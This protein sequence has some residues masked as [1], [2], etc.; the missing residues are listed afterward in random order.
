MTGRGAGSIQHEIT[1]G[2]LTLVAI[3]DGEFTMPPGFLGSAEVHAALAGPD[4]QVRLPI[5][6]FLLPGA[7]PLLIDL[8][9]GPGPGTDLLSGGWLLRGLAQAGYRPEDIATIAL[10]HPHPDHVGWLASLDGAL[11]F[12]RARVLLTAAD[13]EYFVG[14]GNGEMAPHIRAALARLLQ[15]GQAE[16]LSD[17]QILAGHVT[18]VMAPGHTPGHTVFAVHDHGQRAVLLGDSMY[19]PQ[20]L[21]HPE[22][23][24]LS[25][26][27]PAMAARTRVALERDLEATGALAA[28]AHFPGLAAA[29]I[30]VG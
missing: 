4:G 18:A 21:S 22:W 19:C 10:T 14:Q 29:R 27:D 26:V 20:Q 5:G 11:V 16:L 6:C 9:Y 7:E 13:A 1:V 25:D 2:E 12:P 24:A 23:A 17:G 28:G 3:S 8:G 30:L 15:H